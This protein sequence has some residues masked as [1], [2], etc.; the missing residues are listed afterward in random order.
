M[1]LKTKPSFIV[2]SPSLIKIP[3]SAYCMPRKGNFWLQC[4]SNIWIQ[5]NFVKD[6]DDIWMSRFSMM[7]HTFAIPIL[8]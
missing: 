8:N 6:S 4:I 5:D 1:S 7:A 3:I 2:S